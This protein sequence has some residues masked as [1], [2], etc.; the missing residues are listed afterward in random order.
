MQFKQLTIFDY[1]PK[2]EPK[3]NEEFSI[4]EFDRLFEVG[5]L[6]IELDP[7]GIGFKYAGPDLFEITD[8]LPGHTMAQ[9]KNITLENQKKYIG[10]RYYINKTQYNI[11]YKIYEGGQNGVIN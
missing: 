7:F 3:Q 1:L 4:E 2:P 8:I 10:A 9:I 11:G 6:F 5:S